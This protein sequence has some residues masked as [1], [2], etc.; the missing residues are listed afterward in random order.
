MNNA[1]TLVYQW[2]LGI[3][4]NQTSRGSQHLSTFIAKCIG[5]LSQELMLNYF[6]TEGELEVEEGR[7]VAIATIL[8]VPPVKTQATDPLPHVA[9]VHTCP[10]LPSLA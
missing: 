6:L 4:N 7:C 3:A 5:Y 10:A 1:I 9:L 8:F 2:I